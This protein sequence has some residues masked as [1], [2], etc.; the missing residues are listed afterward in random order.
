VAPLD[1]VTAEQ[2]EGVEYWILQKRATAPAAE[3][4]AP[5]AW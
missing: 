4:D 1:A 5:R 3:V 2:L